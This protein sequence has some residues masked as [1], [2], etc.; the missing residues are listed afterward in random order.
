MSGQV[1]AG[2]VGG[3]VSGEWFVVRGPLS[4][5]PALTTGVVSGRTPG[6]RDEEREGEGARLG[7][8]AGPLP[9]K[10]LRPFPRSNGSNISD[11][12]LPELTGLP[13]ADPELEPPLSLGEE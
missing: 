5:P 3:F 12:A 4:E 13:A 7:P 6:G 1:G 9:T 11:P 8:F 10:P 2:V